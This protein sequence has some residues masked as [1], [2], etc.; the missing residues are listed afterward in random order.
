MEGRS[1]MEKIES[2]GR[3]N[4]PLHIKYRPR[5]WDEIKG[6]EAVVEGLKSL[7]S[8]KSE[9]NRPH[10][11]LFQGASGCGKTTLARIVKDELKCSEANFNELNVANTRGIDTIRDV[12]QFSHF[13]TF[14]GGV[15]IFLFDEA[16]K[17]TNDA[18]NAL[19]KVLEDTPP[20]VYFI[21]CT[22]EPKKIIET[23]KTRCTTCQVNRLSNSMVRDLLVRVC[24]EEGKK[25]ADEVLEA[26]SKACNGSPRQALVSLDQVIDIS[27]SPK[28]LELI[29]HSTVGQIKAVKTPPSPKQEVKKVLEILKRGDPLCRMGE[30]QT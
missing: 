23:I 18:Q 28:A 5:T 16:H 1:M 13:C 4:G 22:T 6:N 25:V 8:L 30:S 2:G 21:F 27:D 29:I 15:R 19:L 10:V 9:E 17:L 24:N 26:I 20:K 14:D 12:I 3:P 11:Y 7:F